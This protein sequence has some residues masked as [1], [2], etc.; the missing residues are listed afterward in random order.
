MLRRRNRHRDNRGH[1]R[2]RAAVACTKVTWFC[3]CRR[4]H[5]PDKRTDSGCL[6]PSPPSPSRNTPG[7]RGVPVINPVLELIAMP[8]GRLVAE[9]VT[10]SPSASLPITCSSTAAAVVVVRCRMGARPYGLDVCHSPREA[11]ACAE[12]PVGRSHGH[13]VTAG[14]YERQQAANRCRTTYRSSDLGASPVAL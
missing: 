5:G 10:A 13:V 4:L 6:R 1:G 14:A 3:L 9:N 2:N 11:P 12:R 7:R 8:A